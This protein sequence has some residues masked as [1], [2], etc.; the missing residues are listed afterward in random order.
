MFASRSLDAA[1]VP[2]YPRLREEDLGNGHHVRHIP[3][4]VWTNLQQLQ[5][6]PRPRCA[7]RRRVYTR[8]GQLRN[9]PERRLQPSQPE[10]GAMP[11]RLGLPVHHDNRGSIQTGLPLLAVIHSRV[12]HRTGGPERTLL[13][14]GHS[15]CNRHTNG[16]RHAVHHF[17]LGRT[18]RPKGLPTLAST[19]WE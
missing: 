5:E 19:A 12:L 15:L 6:L 11:A 16:C 14:L 10:P 4:T 7:C 1:H 13:G 8:C 2:C 9:K 3:A 17:Q 18:L